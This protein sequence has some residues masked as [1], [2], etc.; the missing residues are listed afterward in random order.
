M[1][2]NSKRIG[3]NFEREIAKKLSLWITKGER[4]DVLWRN[5]DSGSRSTTRKK[6]GLTSIQDGDFVATD[7]TYDW[8]TKALYIDSKCYKEFNP[9]IINESNIKSNAIFQQWIKVCNDCPDTKVPL[10]V[11][12]IRDRR[13]PQFVVVSSN[14]NYNVQKS[15]MIYYFN[16]K[17][18]GNNYGCM[19]FLLDD[20]L[21]T[22]DARD[23]VTL[24]LKSNF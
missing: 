12:H 21:A 23:I 5:L 19:I 10:M 15:I 20:F 17:S 18:I 16:D 8:F 2:K 24:N 9:F 4:D 1:A 14:F 13:T 11:C 3:N 7:L 22:E 6:Q